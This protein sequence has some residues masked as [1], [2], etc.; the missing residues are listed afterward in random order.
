MLVVSGSSIQLVSALT[1]GQVTEINND[2]TAT[3]AIAVVVRTCEFDIVASYGNAHESFRG[4]TLDNTTPYYY[5]T[6]I[7][8]GSSLLSVPSSMPS[9]ETTQDPSTMP[10]APDGLN[11]ALT[12]GAD[13]AAPL[14]SDFAGNDSGPGNR[15]GIAALIDASEISIIAAPGI[16]DQTTQNGADHAMRKRCTTGFAILDPR[17]HLDWWRPEHERHSEPKEIS[18]TRTMRRS[19]IPGSW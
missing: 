14:A 12:G 2:L 15:T 5:A 17:A 11:V 16:T 3:P 8:N 18:M 4:L 19:I 13:G 9:D 6:S 10:V 7:I 1:A